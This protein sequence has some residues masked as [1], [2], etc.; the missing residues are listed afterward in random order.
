MANI[1]VTSTATTVTVNFNSYSKVAGVTVKIVQRDQ[2]SLAF[3]EHNAYIELSL[4]N[5]DIAVNVDGQGDYYIVDSVNG[6]A[7]TDNL[8]LLAKLAALI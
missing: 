1:T 7:P 4:G 6:V 2:L 3:I 5:R 8:D